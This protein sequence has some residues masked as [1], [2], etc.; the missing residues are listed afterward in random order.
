[1]KKEKCQEK[2]G[3]GHNDQKQTTFSTD[4]TSIAC[5]DMNSTHPFTDDFISSQ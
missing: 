3:G 4:Y 2:K 1:M 5:T